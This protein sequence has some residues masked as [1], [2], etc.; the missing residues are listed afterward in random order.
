MPHVLAVL[1]AITVV[2]Y[3]LLQVLLH[4]TQHAREPRLVE[5]KFPFLDS[6]IGIFRQRAEY[7]VNLGYI[8]SNR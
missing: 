1:A 4:V 3:L 7:L 5:S 8:C 2:A 6:V